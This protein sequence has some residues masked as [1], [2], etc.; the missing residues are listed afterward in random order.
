MY[1]DGEYH[2]PI[3][4]A[5]AN[6]QSCPRHTADAPCCCSARYPL[7]DASFFAPPPPPT[8][9]LLHTL[10]LPELL[11]LVVAFIIVDADNIVGEAACSACHFYQ[12]RDIFRTLGRLVSVSKF[13]RL[14]DDLP[15]PSACRRRGCMV[16]RT[17]DL[18]SR[19]PAPAHPHS[20]GRVRIASRR[21][22]SRS[23]TVARALWR[24]SIS[25]TSS[26]PRSR[27]PSRR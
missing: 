10:Q 8:S 2:D 15:S 5:R 20:S 1:D 12:E 4:Y 6:P 26:S 17:C 9:T 16:E 21:R 19:A 3:A 24:C 13:L 7:A 23:R 27:W 18:A 25:R 11:H 22:W 14:N